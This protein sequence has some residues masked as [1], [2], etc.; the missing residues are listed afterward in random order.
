MYSES[1]LV[2][3]PLEPRRGSFAEAQDYCGR[4]RVNG[5]GGYRLPDLHEANTLTLPG[6]MPTGVYWT[7]T[8]SEGFGDKALVWSNRKSRA[9]PIAK[10]YEG[11]RYVCIRD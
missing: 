5:R 10:V 4:V 7:R 11:G 1:G 2:A 8:S 3:L 9:S 6:D